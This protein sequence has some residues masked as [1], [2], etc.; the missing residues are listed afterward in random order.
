MTKQ[1]LHQKHTRQ[2]HHQQKCHDALCA[3]PHIDTHSV[4]AQTV[5]MM[6]GQQSMQTRALRDLQI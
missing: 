5:I 1:T 4:H 6:R 2:T 3:S